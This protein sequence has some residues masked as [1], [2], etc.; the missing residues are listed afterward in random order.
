VIRR[1]CE[2][3]RGAVWLRRG[4]CGGGSRVSYNRVSCGHVVRGSK[5]RQRQT[6]GCKL[7]VVKWEM[8]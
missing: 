2:V 4:N 3:G 5:G 1:R 7:E 6:E 8:V